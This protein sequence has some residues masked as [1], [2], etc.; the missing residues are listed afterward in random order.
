[1]SNNYNICSNIPLKLNKLKNIKS[2]LN[3]KKRLFHFIPRYCP[4]TCSPRV[5]H[6][7]HSPTSDVWHLNGI[8]RLLSIRCVTIKAAPPIVAI[9]ALDRFH[10][11]IK[12]FLGSCAKQGERMRKFAISWES[13]LKVEKVCNTLVEKLC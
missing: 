9:L 3:L 4:Q 10:N 2:F 7:C 1:M 12:S 6:C 13:V 11:R 8:W 5:R